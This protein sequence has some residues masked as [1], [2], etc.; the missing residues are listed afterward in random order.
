MTAIHAQYIK[1]CLLTKSYHFAKLLLDEDIYEIN[2]KCLQPSDYLLYFYYGGMVYVGL[3]NYVR[4]YDFFKR[5]FIL[6]YQFSFFIIQISIFFPFYWSFMGLF[7]YQILKKAFTMPAV[8]PSAIMIESYKKF[9]LVSLILNGKLNDFP[10]YT[11][12]VCVR[13]LKIV[14]S[15]Y[16]NFAKTY[17]KNDMN[18]L[19]Q[20]FEEHNQVFT[21]VTNDFLHYSPIIPVLMTN[22]LTNL[23]RIKMLGS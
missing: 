13:H 21:Q 19:K 20:H 18:A 1:L 3:K 11:P 14:C 6:L 9:V 22:T 16:A 10:S 23:S 12:S 2:P 8:E 17:A 4:A 5:V 15:V 7:I